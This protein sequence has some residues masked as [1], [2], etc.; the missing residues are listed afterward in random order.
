MVVRLD[1]PDEV[2]RIVNPLE[3][4]EEIKFVL[5]SRDVYAPKRL[6]LEHTGSWL[7]V[8][9]VAGLGYYAVKIVGVYPEN[10][11]HGLPLVR[12]RLLLFSSRSGELLLDAE[13]SAPTGWRT[14]A[15]TALAL[16]V[17]GLERG[18]V[19]GV[20]GAGV[21]ADYHLRLLV[22]IYGFYD[23]L[24]YDV[25]YSR[26]ERLAERHGARP[27]K[28]LDRLL[29]ESDVVV[30]A[31]TSRTPVVRG[32][33]LKR[34]AFVASIGAPRPV[35][36]LDSETIARAGCVLVDTREGVMSESDDVVGADEVVELGEVLRG[37]KTCGPRDLRV[38][39]SVG[40]A[41]FDLAIAIHLYRRGS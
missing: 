32:R 34:G 24:V 12:G 28:S 17:L 26:A 6:G 41:V 22:P 7:G 11:R 35:R 2:D 31:T 25:D 15:A 19:L 14:A 16:R 3:L 10:P 20:I 37:E 40:T 21:Q 27:V 5:S 33:L 38:Y 18:G 30:A 4:I 39:K 9:P 8:M 13:A 1:Y 36:E 23:V 29:E